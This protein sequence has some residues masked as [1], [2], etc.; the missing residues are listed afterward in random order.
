MGIFFFFTVVAVTCFY[1]YYNVQPSAFQNAKCM[2]IWVCDKVL[3]LL[4]HWHQIKTSLLADSPDCDFQ[5]SV[6]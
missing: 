1:H 5:Y 2:S 6:V 3:S 4:C